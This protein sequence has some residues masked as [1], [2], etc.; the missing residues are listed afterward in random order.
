VPLAEK[1]IFTA[2][3]MGNDSYN[4]LMVLCCLKGVKK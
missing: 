4:L 3:G 2:I 1:E